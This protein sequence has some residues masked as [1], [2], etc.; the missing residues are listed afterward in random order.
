MGNKQDKPR[1][2][3]ASLPT[4]NSASPAQNVTL[5]RKLA[6]AAKKRQHD[7]NT[8]IP[9]RRKEY[10]T[11]DV[12][13][14]DSL[15]LSAYPVKADIPNA[16]FEVLELI[17][18]GAFGNVLKV[19]QLEDQNIYAMKA[20]RKS[21]VLLDRAV[22]QCNQGSHYPAVGDHAFIVKPRW[23]FQNKNDV[24][25]VMDYM[26]RGELFT[27]WKRVE[28][29]S[30]PLVRICIAQLAIAIDFL[31]SSGVIYRDLK[32]ENV[33]I[34]ANAYAITELFRSAGSEIPLAYEIFRYRQLIVFGTRQTST[35]I[36]S[37]RK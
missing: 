27:V 1:S 5:M 37:F 36:Q 28:H 14:I 31:H 9:H 11:A 10:S 4:Q 19:R 13:F 29:F 12:H 21:K 7:L 25:I 20:M 30:E 22:E 35:G 2:R 18:R 17:A 23:F 33:L 26:P 24:F 8:S 34:D 32:M 16:H 6:R 15:F 3:S